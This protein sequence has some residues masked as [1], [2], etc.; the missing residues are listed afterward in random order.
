MSYLVNKSNSNET[1]G[2][3]TLLGEPK[4]AIITLAIPMIIAMSAHTIYNLFDALWVSGFGQEFFT[5]E[6]IAEIGTGALAAVGFVM[7]FFMMIISIS[8]G[9]GVGAGS[10]ISRKIGANDKEGADNVAVHSIIITL[11]ISI[12]F[13]ILFYISAEEIF[14][15]IGAKEA[16]GMAVS[17]GRIIFAGGIFLFFSNVAYA[18]L[19]GEGDAKRAMY[20][21]MFGAILNIGLI[22]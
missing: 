3:K 7:P 18:I 10:A 12:I 9:I 11:I 14:S 6:T 4:K 5:N 2:V 21:M 1:K 15:L 8:V 19:R 13:S 16:A 20:A 22:L 17:Y